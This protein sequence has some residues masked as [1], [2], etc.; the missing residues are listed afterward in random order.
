MSATRLDD[1]DRAFLRALVQDATLGAGALGRRYAYA[2]FFRAAIPVRHFRTRNLD[3]ATITIDDLSELAP[4]RD[5]AMD[6]I[7]ATILTDA[8]PG[9]DACGD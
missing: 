5:A 2:F 8:R 3:V 7:C 4:G 9:R 6:A 1:I